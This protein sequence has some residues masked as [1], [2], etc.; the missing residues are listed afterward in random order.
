MDNQ[1]LTPELLLN[2]AGVLDG[3]RVTIAGILSVG[4]ELAF[5]EF[6]DSTIKLVIRDKALKRKLL[7]SVPC[8]LGGDYLYH[9]IVRLVGVLQNVDGKMEVKLVESGVLTC[10]G[11]DFAF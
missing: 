9:D 10:E 4:G 2:A 8:L 5:V 11:E 6:P 1:I 7:D 3:K